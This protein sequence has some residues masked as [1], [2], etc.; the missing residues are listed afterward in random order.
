MNGSSVETQ[1]ERKFGSRRLDQ[2]AS[3]ADLRPRA[4][5]RINSIA[6]NIFIICGDHNLTENVVHTVLARLPDAPENAPHG[7]LP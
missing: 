7:K 1:E 2:L 4:A 6:C 5:S 3:A